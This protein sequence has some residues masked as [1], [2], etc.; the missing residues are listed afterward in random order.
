MVTIVDVAKMFKNIVM[1]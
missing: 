1:N